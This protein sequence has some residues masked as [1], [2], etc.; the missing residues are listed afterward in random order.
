MFEYIKDKYKT[1]SNNEDKKE[2]V[3][4]GVGSIGYVDL[5][6]TVSIDLL[7]TL[8]LAEQDYSGKTLP[9]ITKEYKETGRI[10]KLMKEKINEK[11][12]TL[13]GYFDE[14]NENFIQINVINENI[15]SAVIFK[16]HER[17]FFNN[18]KGVFIDK[19]HNEYTKELWTNQIIGD[20]FF[21]MQTPNGEYEYENVYGEKQTMKTMLKDDKHLVPTKLTEC[22]YHRGIESNEVNRELVLISLLESEKECSINIYTGLDV[23][24]STL[25][26]I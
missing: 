11:M 22:L 20:N 16:R 3:V 5:G 25:K 15:D 1:I 7:A 2:N 24:V 19:D 12:Y 13:R 9:L 17:M 6:T 23:S 10:V 8:I 14:E 4:K 18:K 26:L 21:L